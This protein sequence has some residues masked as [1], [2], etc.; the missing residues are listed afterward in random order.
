MTRDY[1]TY[2]KEGFV[3]RMLQCGLT[4]LES[5]CERWKVKIYEGQNQAISFSY[6]RRP[7][8]NLLS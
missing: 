1:T 5:W 6:H 2:R 3:I 4:L 7:V 8:K